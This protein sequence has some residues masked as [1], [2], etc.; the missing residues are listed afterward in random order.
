MKSSSLQRPG[1]PRSM[2]QLEQRT[3]YRCGHDRAKDAFIQRVDD[4]HYGM[5]SE[6]LSEILT[7]RSKGKQRLSHTDTH[8]T[9][10]LCR[11]VLPRSE[12]TQRSN[13]TFFSA[14][15]DCNKHVFA[16]RR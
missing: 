12:F 3:C 6:C 14:C 16:Q 9:C 7:K 5:C 11:K 15:K 8:R 13:G 10:Y 4:R 2:Q 1:G